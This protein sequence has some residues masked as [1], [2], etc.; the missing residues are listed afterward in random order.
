[1]RRL[2]FDGKTAIHPAQ[3]EVINQAFSPSPEEVTRA[4]RVAEAMAEAIAA[5]RYVATVDGEMV[6]ALHLKAARRT[7][8]QAYRLGLTDQEPPPELP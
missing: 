2:G 3:I 4:R 7:L 6:E 8:D 1:V 5:G